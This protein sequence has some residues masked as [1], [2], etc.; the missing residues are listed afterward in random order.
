MLW[1]VIADLGNTNPGEISAPHAN[2]RTLLGGPTCSECHGEKADDLP[3]ACLGCHSD[4][5]ADIERRFGLHGTLDT[6]NVME[7]AQCHSEHHGSAFQLVSAT[8][9]A[10]AGFDDLDSFE[11]EMFDY[12]LHGKHLEL[13]CTACHELAEVAA[14]EEGQKRYMGLTQ[15]CTTCHED[16]HQGQLEDDCASCHGQDE[17]FDLVAEFE[18]DERFPL[19]GVHGEIGCKQCHPVV[20]PYSIESV[21]GTNPPDRRNCSDCH[22]SPHAG[23]FLA[24][25]YVPLPEG[26]R[27]CSACHLLDHVGFSVTRTSYAAADHAATGFELSAPHDRLECEQCHPTPS[28]LEVPEAYEE[29]GTFASYAA[30]FPGRQQDDCA[31]CHFDP[32]G[33]QFQL[34]RQDDRACLECHQRQ[35]FSPPTFDQARHAETGFPL[36]GG[37]AQLE[38]TACHTDV[39]PGD[40]LGPIYASVSTSCSSCHQDVHQACFAEFAAENGVDSLD[41]D[42]CHGT[43][44]FR[45]SSGEEFEHG[46]WTAFDLKG[47]H[48]A[49]ECWSCHVELSEPTTEGRLFGYAP[50]LLD[51]NHDACGSCHQDVHEGRF[52]HPDAPTSVRGRRSCARCHNEDSFL[53]MRDTT[54]DHEM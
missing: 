36:D 25:T 31:S 7:C 49:I 32:H 19:D 38:C 3:D 4:V 28:L 54:F 11:H 33:G 23:S 40:E 30:R 42:Q 18:H 6:S 53:E 24:A 17:A 29:S 47:K 27:D 52:D 37:H 13:D 34:D 16:P 43:G 45:S 51:K 1:L 39:E 44:T 8:S 46:A 9:F 26:Q 15:D 14:L 41:C 12:Q 48:A 50:D 20:G 22:D 21:G 10:L 2:I 35:H 5:K